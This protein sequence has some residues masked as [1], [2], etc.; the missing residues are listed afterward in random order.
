MAQPDRSCPADVDAWRVVAADPDERGV[1]PV[2]L[3]ALLQDL[4]SELAA[5]FPYAMEFVRPG[6]DE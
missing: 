4:D 5:A 6:F 1:N 3:M 2:A